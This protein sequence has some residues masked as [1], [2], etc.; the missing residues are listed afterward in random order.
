M[1]FKSSVFSLIACLLHLLVSE[2]GMGSAPA[3]TVE[4]LFL[5]SIVRW[6]CITSTQ[7]CWNYPRSP[8]HVYFQFRVEIWKAE[9]NQS[10]FLML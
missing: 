7:L 1:S 9:V 5:P 2:S 4:F 6:P 3:I 8:F 10:H